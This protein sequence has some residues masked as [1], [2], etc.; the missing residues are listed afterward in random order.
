MNALTPYTTNIWTHV[1]VLRDF[2][3]QVEDMFGRRNFFFHLTPLYYA[4]LSNVR[5][6]KNATIALWQNCQQ[7]L[8]MMTH[9]F[10][11]LLTRLS[12]PQTAQIACWGSEYNRSELPNKQLVSGPFGYFVGLLK[13]TSL[14]NSGPKIIQKSRSFLNILGAIR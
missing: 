13:K 11:L 2:S 3:D 14:Y 5:S 4:F 12:A 9:C 8:Y 10:D 1:L 6:H 7:L